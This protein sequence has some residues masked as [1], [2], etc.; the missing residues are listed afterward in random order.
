M[1]HKQSETKL[2]TPPCTG[3][4][5]IALAGLLAC[6]LP[7]AASAQGLDAQALAALDPDMWTD[8]M[9]L[10]APALSQVIRR[11][12][13]NLHAYRIALDNRDRERLHAK[14]TYSSNRKRRINLPG[15][16]QIPLSGE[17]SAKR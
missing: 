10:N 1:L 2:S 5:R 3:L 17:G 9:G 7:L 11:L 13:E 8:L 14:L 6:G 4:R 16:G 15:S 12:E